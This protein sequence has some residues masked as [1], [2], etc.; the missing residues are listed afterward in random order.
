MRGKW[1]P[2]P[3]AGQKGQPSF[4]VLTSE[5]GVLMS[6]RGSTTSK[7]PKEGGWRGMLSHTE[8]QSH[9][10]TQPSPRGTHRDTHSRGRLTSLAHTTRHARNP[11]GSGTG[12]HDPTAGPAGAPGDSVAGLRAGTRI[13]DSGLRPEAHMGRAEPHT[14]TPTATCTHPAPSHSHDQ[15][16]RATRNIAQPTPV[17]L[18]TVVHAHSHPDAARDHTA[19]TQ[20]TP[21]SHRHTTSVTHWSR[22]PS[23]EG[24]L[25][26]FHAPSLRPTRLAGPVTSPLRLSLPRGLK[27]AGPNPSLTVGTYEYADF[28]AHSRPSS[29]QNLR[30]YGSGGPLR[31]RPHMR[32]MTKL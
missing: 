10:V 6:P 15:A 7:P 21:R 29:A 16:P 4:E 28:Q 25:P 23:R 14:A 30:P 22:A 31:D 8:S 2:H 17:S 19:P 20:D 12:A 32:R 1:V 18:P 3:P 9:T 5:A 13:R 27:G 26:T 24:D 11:P